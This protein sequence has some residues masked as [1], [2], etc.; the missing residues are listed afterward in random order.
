MVRLSVAGLF[1]FGMVSAVA[2]DDGLA[3]VS[4]AGES[5][6]TARRLAAVDAH[7]EAKQ[8]PEAVKELQRILDEAGDDLVPDWTMTDGVLR[9]DQR[10]ARQA[11]WLCHQRLAALPAPALAL[12]RQRV[13]APARH[14]FDQ[15]QRERD[16]PVLRK[17]VQQMFCARAADDALDLLGDLACE[18][19]DLE[20][21]E[22]W[23]RF[24]TP[25]VAQLGGA[26]AL[27]FPDSRLAPA[28]VRAKQLLARALRGE[29]IRVEEFRA[30]YPDEV[31]HLAGRRGNLAAILEEVVRAELSVVNAEGTWETFAGDASRRGVGRFDPARLRQFASFQRRTFRIQEN[32]S[33]SP[34]RPVS[35]RGGAWDPV[36]TIRPPSGHTRPLLP[37]HPVIAEDYVVVAAAE[38]VTAHGLSNERALEYHLPGGATPPLADHLQRDA[39][40]TLT[41]A[42]GRIFACLGQTRLGQTGGGTAPR[43]FLVCLELDANRP[44]LRERWRV[45]APREL[46]AGAT[47]EGA[48][49]VRRGRVF[50]ALI[51]ADGERERT[52]LACHDAA[53]GE[54]LWHCDVCTTEEFQQ[55]RRRAR[56]HLLTWAGD[57]LVYCTHTGAIFAVEPE[58]GQTLWAVRY[59]RRQER[60]Q[61]VL[62]GPAP[63]VYADGLIYVAPTDHDRVLCLMAETGAV[64]W[65]STP[66]EVLHLLGIESG[67]L[68]L[69]ATTPYACVRTLDA[70]TGAAVR[71]LLYPEEDAGATSLGRGVLAGG[72][73]LWP[74]AGGLCILDA[75]TLRPRADLIL[76]HNLLRGNIVVANGC[77]VVAGEDTLTV[78]KLSRDRP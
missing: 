14:L 21:A 53:T 47:F 65:E 15:G 36:S 33:V 35:G 46:P 17:L 20:E 68:I 27:R 9:L 58:T 3:R 1:L 11:R 28:L 30:K 5:A 31:G 75:A 61:A 18:R 40:F 43:S 72:A 77:L 63:C 51:R 6:Q 22:R 26:D 38:R 32:T 60:G 49:L 56:H 25:A 39:A 52:T 45:P 69:T 2:G 16:A 24:L 34:R 66:L 59:P 74:T 42:D 73:V 76:G 19:G 23:W 55:N 41:A 50:S 13:D 37:F 54:P 44:Q 78:L 29:T 48:P 12:Y 62:R 64:R 57:R 67:H 10:H 8:W 70:H 71:G 7:L 4:L